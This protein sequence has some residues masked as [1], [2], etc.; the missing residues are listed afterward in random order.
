MVTIC[1]LLS[2]DARLGWEKS[3][4]VV[5]SCDGLWRVASL[6]AGEQIGE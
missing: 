6:N 5:G 4:D 2:I 3:G 1:S